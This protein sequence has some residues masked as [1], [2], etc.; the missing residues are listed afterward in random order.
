MSAI[1]N[2]EPLHLLRTKL[3]RPRPAGDLVRRRRL[4]EILDGYR[5]RT[6]TL[7][8]APAGFGKTTLLTDWLE[9]CE[10]P[11]AWLSL[12]KSDGE[13]GVFLAYFVA[14]VRTLFPSACRGDARIAG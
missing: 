10:C 1:S 7:I 12:D 11:S 9:H 4:S 2:G 13:L 3:Y 14:A 5:D 6:V 8:C